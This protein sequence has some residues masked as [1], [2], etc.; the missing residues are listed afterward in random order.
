MNIN[1]IDPSCR[2]EYITKFFVQNKVSQIFLFKIMSIGNN[3]TTLVAANS[4]SKGLSRMGGVEAFPSSH[5]KH[6]IKTRS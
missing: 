1:N 5:Q 3:S 2:S 6:G 4:G